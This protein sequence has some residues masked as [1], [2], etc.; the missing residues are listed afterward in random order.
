VETGSEVTVHYDPLLAKLVTWGAT[1]EESVARMAEALRR[2]AVLG[3]TT[4]LE[5]LQAIV[6]HPAFRRGALHTAFLEEHLQDLQRV[7]C[8]P[9]EAVAAAAL[10]LGP[11]SGG[12]AGS[13]A[14]ADRPRLADPWQTL[15]GW[16]LG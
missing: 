7:P 13:G 9:P 6:A 12:A 4:N 2:T 5:R 14:P 8:P 10:A 1:R 11:D 16:R 15:G 3:V